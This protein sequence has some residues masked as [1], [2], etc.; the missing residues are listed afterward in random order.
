MRLTQNLLGYLPRVFERDPAPF[1]ALRLRYAGGLTWRVAD[2]V[3]TTSPID[4]PVSATLSLDF[5]EQAYQASPGSVDLQVDLSDHTLA[6]LFTL[7]SAQ[8]GYSAPFLTADLAGLSAL[9]LIDGEGDQGTV[10]GDR[11]MGY[12]SLAYAYME[13]MAAELAEAGAE[14]DDM[15]TQLD[16]TTAEG[17]WLE[18]WGARYAVPRLTGEPDPAYANRIIAEVIRPRGNNVAIAAAISAYTGQDTTVTDA[19]VWGGPNPAYNAV[20][21]HNA[22]V[23]HSSTATPIYGLFDVNYGYDLVEGGSIAAFQQT[24]RGLVE[25]LRDAGTQLRALTL[26]GGALV[27][28]APMGREA[29]ARQLVY[30]RPAL[31][32]TAAIDDAL[33]GADGATVLADSSAAPT[34]ATDSLS[35]TYDHTYRGTLRYTGGTPYGGGLVLT[36]GI[37]G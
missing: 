20:R 9:T 28:E 27:D 21:T 6:S 16:T 36:G 23:N 26:A 35:V 34:D 10:Y 2:G 1:V 29:N 3:L 5:L 14:I 30:V 4:G 18:D 32:D 33:L 22:A 12:T 37:A 15:L 19:V 17:E 25:R 13:T 8:P 7:L 11:L 31:T 24:V